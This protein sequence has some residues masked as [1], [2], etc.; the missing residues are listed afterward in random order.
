VLEPARPTSARADAARVAAGR[1]WDGTVLLAA[2]RAGVA[3]LE[4][5]VDDVNRLNV[6]PVPDGDTGSNMVATVRAALVEAERRRRGTQ[7]SVGEIAAALADGALMGARGNSGV[8]TSQVLAGLASALHGKRRAR[9]ADLARGLHEGATA[10]YASVAQP[11]EGTILTVIREAAD[12]AM[13]AARRDNDTDTVL[14]AAV[15]AARSAVRRTPTL[16]AILRESGVVD[17]GGQGLYLLL[18]GARQEARA[19]AAGE[20]GGTRPRLV[21]RRGGRRVASPPES[22]EPPSRAPTLRPAPIAAFGYETMFMLR[23]RGPGELDLDEIRVRLEG[24]GESVVVAGDRHAAKIHLHT[25][26]PDAV[27]ALAIQ[28]GS[29][30]QIT[31]ED[32]DE[33]DTRGNALRL[34]PLEAPAALSRT[35]PRAAVATVA[36]VPGDGFEAA[37]A[38]FGVRTIRGGQSD[39]PS[40]GELT[41]AVERANADA[42]LLLPNSPNA[43]LAAHKAATVAARWTPPTEVHVVPTRNAAEG[44]ASVIE[45]DADRSA[46]ANAARMT[47]AARSVRTLVVASAVR[48]AAIGG[49]AVRSGDAIV[50]DPGDGLVAV[51]PD[52][53]TAVLAAIRALGG[54]FELVT[55]YYGIGVDHAEAE[56]LGERV[57]EA[58]HGVE[59]D[60]VDG[61][62]PHHRYVISAE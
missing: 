23:A 11:V 35:T 33:D 46:A 6:Y 7:S 14:T 55:L 50:L 49:R 5:H 48:D 41:D 53:N 39:N 44:L 59:V 54:A 56:A 19:R 8:I 62:Q 25:G 60:V 45:V 16:L 32:L 43:L 29:L 15:T 30:S 22:V 40:V 26:R 61:G 52:P 9:G 17:A 24:V 57:R 12:A 42:V 10:A 27:I 20:A 36:I 28:A 13:S 21:V 18:D 58:F 2:F 1:G 51:A 4:A 47:A 34:V 3:E 38:S 37:F 31:I